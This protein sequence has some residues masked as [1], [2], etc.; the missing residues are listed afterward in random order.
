LLWR[1]I[2]KQQ[3]RDLVANV[4]VAFGATCGSDCSR[5]E[6]GTLEEERAPLEEV[7]WTA[8][9]QAASNSGCGGLTHS[10]QARVGSGCVL[11]PVDPWVQRQQV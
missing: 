5:P 11:L 7:W 4:E 9:G 6:E 10:E 2:D 8:A 1:A 3:S